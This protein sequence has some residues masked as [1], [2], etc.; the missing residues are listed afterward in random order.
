MIKYI[1]LFLFFIKNVFA[2]QINC[3][4]E[5]VYQDGSVQNGIILISEKKLRY[6][7]L[8]PSLY[9]IIKNATGLYVVA[10]YQKKQSERIFD[11][12]MNEIFM[13]Y[14]DFPNI[15][16]IYSSENFEANVYFSKEHIFLS[17]ISILSQRANLSIHF[18]N[19][20]NREISDLYFRVNPLHDYIY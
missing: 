17:R 6:E 2:L 11:P 12:L 19:C 15:N 16:N 1:L 10:N 3:E 5:E 20:E 4:F 8:D 14:D 18:L 9:T 13:I 7:Y